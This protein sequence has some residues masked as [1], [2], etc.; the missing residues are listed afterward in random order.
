M[1]TMVTYMAPYIGIISSIHKLAYITPMTMVIQYI[2]IYLY[3][4]YM[5]YIYI[6]IHLFTGTYWNCTSKFGWLTDFWGC[7]PSTNLE[8][9]QFT[10]FLPKVSFIT[11]HIGN[12]HRTT[13][14][15]GIFGD[16]P[17]GFRYRSTSIDGTYGLDDFPVKSS[18]FSLP[19]YWILWYNLPFGHS[20]YLWK[21]AIL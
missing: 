20:T 7:A 4:Q 14:Y 17:I 15:L 5:I 2:Y 16:C 19:C 10:E 18:T 3:T 8:D 1:A 21:S 9:C 11:G 13:H 6:Y 12:P